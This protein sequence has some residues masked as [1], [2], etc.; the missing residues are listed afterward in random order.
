MAASRSA[1]PA[2]VMVLVACGSSL[3][4]AV[5]EDGLRFMGSVVQVP[6][7]DEVLLDFTVT[8]RNGALRRIQRT[9]LGGCFIDRIRL[10]RESPG[11]PTLVWDTADRLDLRAC[12]DDLVALDLAPGEIAGPPTWRAI[13]SPSDQGVVIVPGFY[14]AEITLRF[15]DELERLLVDDIRID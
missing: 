1:L 15:E 2:L 6:S 14:S 4:P 5:E 11:E 13:R 9:L 7:P 8:V 10:F 3:G 12:T